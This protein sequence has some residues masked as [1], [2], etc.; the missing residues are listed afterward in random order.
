MII[1]PIKTYR[2][3]VLVVFLSLI[4]QSALALSL[5][6]IHVRSH[7]AEPFLAEI[8][9]PSYDIDETAS[10]DIHLA[11]AEQ[12]KAMGYE[13]SDT[14]KRFQFSIKENTE[15]KLYIEVRSASAVKELSISLLIEVI[16]VNGRIIKGYDILLTPKAISSIFDSQNENKME[17]EL[18]KPKSVIKFRLA[19]IEKIKPEETLEKTESIQIKNEI[20]HAKVKQDVTLTSK[21]SDLHSKVKQLPEGG[22][23]YSKIGNGE[24]LSRIAQRIRP[25]KSMHMKQVMIALYKENPNAFVNG[26]INHLIQG[27]SLKLRN[28]DSI[29]DISVSR[30]SELVLQYS[31]SS[32]AN[33]NAALSQNNRTDKESS[34]IIELEVNRLEISNNEDILSAEFLDEA[35]SEKVSGLENEL[36]NARLMIDKLDIKNKALN[37]RIASLEKKIEV[38]T[39]AFFSPQTQKETNTTE[40]SLAQSGTAEKPPTQDTLIVHTDMVNEEEKNYS[41]IETIEQNKITFALIIIGILSIILITINKKDSILQAINKSK[42]PLQNKNNMFN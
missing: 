29:K 11:S 27:S 36:N 4:S 32:I 38:T 13:I 26:N 15:G 17:N 7:F 28:I 41:F 31:N 23:Q 24:S 21:K 16:S 25:H 39:K 35:H 18:N 10:I 8:T 12:H 34:S 22:F 6:D 3:I 40:E 14:T 33:S 20:S 2:N 30:A 9:L 1:K 37:E 42:N 19:N 5:G